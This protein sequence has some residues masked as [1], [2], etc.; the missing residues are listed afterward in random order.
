M[1]K[2]T[3]VIEGKTFTRSSR[4]QYT[5]V[6]TFVSK[7]GSG[8]DGVA[9]WCKTK[10]AAERYAAAQSGNKWAQGADYAVVEIAA[11]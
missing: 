4:S 6:V 9:R 10:A 11:A 2:F 3:V 8:D 7:N 5:H 1:N